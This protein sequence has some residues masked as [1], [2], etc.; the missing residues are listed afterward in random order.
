RCAPLSSEASTAITSASRRRW[1]TRAGAVRRPFF[2]SETSAGSGRVPIHR[3]SCLAPPRSPP[4]KATIMTR[5]GTPKP[6]AAAG[7]TDPVANHFAR[8]SYAYPLEHT[9][10]IHRPWLANLPSRILF[11]AEGTRCLLVHGSPRQVNEFLWDSTSPDDFLEH[12]VSSADVDVLLC[13]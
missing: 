3:S 5:G 4:R 12:L 10:A 6:T 8:I 13:T 11:D 2:A 9:S 7:T 1:L